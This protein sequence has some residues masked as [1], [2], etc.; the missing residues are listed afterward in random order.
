MKKQYLSK[1]TPLKK[2][3]FLKTKRSGHKKIDLT[4]QL[5]RQRV[6]LFTFLVNLVARKCE[7]HFLPWSLIISYLGSKPVVNRSAETL[8]PDLPEVSGQILSSLCLLIQ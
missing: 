6:F 1:F 4:I 2:S 5:Q 3:R 7:D 8:H